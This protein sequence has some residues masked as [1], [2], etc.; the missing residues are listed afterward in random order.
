MDWKRLGKVVNG[1]L[2]RI[3]GEGAPLSPAERVVYCAY[4]LDAEVHNG[5]FDQFFFNSQ[6]NLAAETLDALRAIGAP[7]SAGFLRQACDAFAPEE[8]S[9]DRDVRWTQMDRV[10]KELREGWHALDT[11]YYDCGERVPELVYA[12]IEAHP[13]EFPP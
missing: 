4:F 7:K 11:L 10:P 12:Y 1:I 8:P 3:Y 13:N 6:G 9:P 5:G 2:D